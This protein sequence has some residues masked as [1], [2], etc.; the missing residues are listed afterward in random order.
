[1]NSKRSCGDSFTKKASLQMSGVRNRLRA[2]PLLLASLVG[3]EHKNI[4]R[5]IVGFIRAV[6]IQNQDA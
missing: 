1:M 6:H 4:Y 3:S 2:I 5:A